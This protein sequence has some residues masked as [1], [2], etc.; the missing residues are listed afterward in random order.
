M[1]TNVHIR[2]YLSLSNLLSYTHMNERKKIFTR[3]A[4]SGKCQRTRWYFVLNLIKIGNFW[5]NIC[6]K[7][8]IFAMFSPRGM[9]MSWRWWLNF[10]FLAIHNRTLFITCL[11]LTSFTMMMVVAIE[12]YVYKHF[13]CHSIFFCEK[14]KRELVFLPYLKT[15]FPSLLPFHSIYPVI[16]FTVQ[17]IIHRKM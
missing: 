15:S 12:I 4:N 16:Q 13:F 6:K 7:V 9:V 17:H 10:L 1:R 5:F 8:E 2:L 14:R 11:L 3:D